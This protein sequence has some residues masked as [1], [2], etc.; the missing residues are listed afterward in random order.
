MSRKLNLKYFIG[1]Y[2]IFR[3]NS[4][5]CYKKKLTKFLIIFS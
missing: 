5:Y 4:T 1:E 2:A 3:Q